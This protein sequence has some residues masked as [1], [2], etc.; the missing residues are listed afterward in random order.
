MRIPLDGVARVKGMGDKSEKVEKPSSA[1]SPLAQSLKGSY[2]C[3]YCGTRVLWEWRRVWTP[4]STW[5]LLAGIYANVYLAWS[6]YQWAYTKA[7]NATVQQLDATISSGRLIWVMVGLGVAVIADVM[8]L[9]LLW[10]WRQ[11]CPRCG[12]RSGG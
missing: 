8:A 2:Q 3:P 10:D 9:R 5:L 12:I 4:S 11:V 6:G 7:I 1:S